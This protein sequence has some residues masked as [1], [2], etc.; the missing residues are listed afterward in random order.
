MQ[1]KRYSARTMRV[2]RQTLLAFL[3]FFD[4]RINLTSDEIYNYLVKVVKD[5]ISQSSHRQLA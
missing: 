2:Y 3:H 1:V 4:D 5:G